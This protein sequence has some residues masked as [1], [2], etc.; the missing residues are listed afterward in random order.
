MLYG[1]S[2]DIMCQEHLLHDLHVKLDIQVDES[3]MIVNVMENGPDKARK[4]LRM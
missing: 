2:R 4:A 3:M 1:L